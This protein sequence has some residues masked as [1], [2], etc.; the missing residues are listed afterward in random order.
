MQ[1]ARSFDGKTVIVTGA[2][3][4]IGRATVDILSAK[5]AHVVAVDL[6]DQTTLNE[7]AGSSHLSYLRGDVTDEQSVKSFVNDALSVS[8]KIDVLINNAGIEGPM[9]EI[10]SL[11]FVDF[12]KVL[13]VNVN[14]VFL[15]MKHVIPI[16]RK[17]GNGCIVNMA[18]TAGMAGTPRASA[19]VASKHAV[20]GLT[21]AAAAEWAGSGVRV[22]C[23]APG[24]IDGR[25]MGS[26]MG[27]LDAVGDVVRQR[28]PSGRFGSPGEVASVIAFLASD[29]ARHIHGAVIPV[30][31]GRTAV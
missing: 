29:D 15:T 17:A 26:I 18:S 8:G 13:A 16:M 28:I 3:G 9:C 2:A 1:G 12:A 23:I 25:M 7:Y 4:D 10:P 11:D 31:G 30:D 6:A 21:R 19:Y 14:G 22:N 20:I 5:G 27:G 24:P